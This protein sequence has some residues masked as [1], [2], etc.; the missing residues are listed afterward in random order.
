M[1]KNQ[2]VIDFLIECP[3]I[4][5]NPL[6]FNFINADDNNKQLI[7][8]GNDVS[9]DQ[10]YIDGSVLKRYTFTLIDF[11]SISYNQIVKIEGYSSENVDDMLEVQD[12]IDWITEQDELGNYPNFGDDCI[13]DSMT[14]LTSNPNLDSVDVS[15]SPALVRYSVSIRIE[16][17]DNS[18]KIWKKIGG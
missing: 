5:N 14:A 18:K 4:R 11:K 12:L 15:I 2:A 3:A 8:V 10:P 6:Y 1:D 17:L 13:I 7:T 9:V 16:Y